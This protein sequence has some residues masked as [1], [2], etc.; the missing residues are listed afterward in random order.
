[1]PE[2]TGDYVKFMHYNGATDKTEEVARVYLTDGQLHWEGVDAAEIKKMVET[3]ERLEPYRKQGNYSLL[4]VLGR[5]INGSMF[6]ATD[7]IEPFGDAQME[8]DEEE[9]EE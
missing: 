6:H 7:I 9:P 8:P 1:M 2:Q 5:Y 3:D 4:S